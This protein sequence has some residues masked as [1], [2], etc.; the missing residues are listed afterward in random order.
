MGVASEQ[1]AAFNPSEVTSQVSGFE[2]KNDSLIR[3]IK[4]G[5]QQF[6]PNRQVR[7]TSNYRRWMTD[8]LKN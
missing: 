1:G 4:L 7:S 6:I 3:K 5:Q 8:R 2:D